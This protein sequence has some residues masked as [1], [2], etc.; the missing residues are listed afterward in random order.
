MRMTPA[1]LII[2]G[3]M[4]YLASI[5]LMVILPAA[6]M[7]GQGPSEIWRQWTADEQAGQKLFIENGCSYC[8]SQ[9]IRNIDWGHGA[10]RIAEPGDYYK[11]LAPILGTERTGPDLSLEGGQHPD[12]WHIAHFT[13]PRYTS[14]YSV[15][16][17]WKF[18]GKDQ[19]NKLTAYMQAEGGKF[20]DPRVARQDKWKKE[21]I[22]AYRKGPDENVE[23]IHEHVPEGWRVLPNPYAASAE[24]LARGEKLYQM[25]CIGCHGPVGDGQGPAAAFL[26]PPPLNFTTVRR[27]LV[28]GKYI[29]GIFYYQI[30]NGITGTGMPYFKR[31]LESEKIWDLG[32]FIAVNFV[33]YTDAGISPKG[34]EASYEP[35]WHNPY[36]I[37]PIIDINGKTTDGN[38]P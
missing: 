9:F 34:I 10:E 31:A 36:L 37:K 13:D 25:Y 19:I 27:H 26:N 33:G 22:A 6:W 18:L 35:I 2:G 30:M 16:P 32:N 8:H 20:S 17:S 29:G 14:P 4:V 24:A 7:S 21:A 28:E 15:M 23:W 38:K 3:I 1:V 11:Q 5:S 12:D